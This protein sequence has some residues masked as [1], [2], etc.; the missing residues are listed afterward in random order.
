[1]ADKSPL[2]KPEQMAA[3]APAVDTAEPFAPGIIDFLTMGVAI[4]LCLILAGGIGVAIDAVAHSTPLWTFVG[5]GFGVVA[6]V[7]VTV[8]LVRKN[9]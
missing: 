6:A 5:L 8:S 1:M 3:P 2:P 7:L 4:A 9:L